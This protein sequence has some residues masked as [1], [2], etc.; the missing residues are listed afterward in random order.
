MLGGGTVDERNPLPDE[1]RDYKLCRV[2]N[3]NPLELDQIPAV[4]SDYALAFDELERGGHG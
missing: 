3:C 2:L 1:W 4:F